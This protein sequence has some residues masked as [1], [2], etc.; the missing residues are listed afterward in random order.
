MLHIFVERKRIKEV[1]FL[2]LSNDEC[3]FFEDTMLIGISKINNLSE[4][5]FKNDDIYVLIGVYY[6]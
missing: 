5:T 2:F 1:N 3:P 4:T 6:K